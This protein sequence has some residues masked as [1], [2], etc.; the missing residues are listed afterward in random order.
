MYGKINFRQFEN[1]KLLAL[2]LKSFPQTFI[3]KFIEN[4]GFSSVRNKVYEAV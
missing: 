2:C 3:K 4:A 1:E